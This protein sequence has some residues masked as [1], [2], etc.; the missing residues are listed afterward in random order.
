MDRDFHYYGTVLAAAC[1]GFSPDAARA[2]G[3]SAQFIDDCT[4]ALTHTGGIFSLGSRAR[5]FNVR[6]S[7]G[8]I[9]PFFPL[10]TSVYGVT[11]WA[12]SS[13]YDETRQIWMPFHFLPGNFPGQRSKLVELRPGIDAQGDLTNDSAESIQLLC[14][15][16]SDSA[17]NMINFARTAFARIKGTDAELAQMVV[18]CV[19]HVFADTYAHQDFAGTASYALNGLK[20]GYSKDPGQF[21]LYGEWKGTQWLPKEDT[22]RDIVWPTNVSVDWLNTYPPLAN[23]IA[24]SALGHGQMGHMPDCS[25]LAI[26]YQPAWSNAAIVRNNPQQYMDAFIDMTLALKCILNNWPFDWNNQQMR[27]DH[28]QSLT[29]GQSFTMIKQLFCPDVKSANEIRM[30]DQG[31]CVPSTEWF[32]KSE[33]R[34]GA[35]LAKLLDNVPFNPIPGYNEA[36]YGW[37]KTVEQMGSDPIPLDTF[38]TLQF[39]KWTIAAK[40]LFRANY[41]QLRGMSNGIGRVI[42]SAQFSTAM[43]PRQS[44]IDEFSR[45]W[46]P[47]DATSQTLNDALVTTAS[48][49]EMNSVLLGPYSTTDADKSSTPD[50]F[51]MQREGRCLS[52]S[53]TSRFSSG[54]VRQAFTP[55]VSADATRA[56]PI[57]LVEFNP[58]EGVYLRTFENRVGKQL[59]L[60]YPES[61]VSKILWFNTFDG[62]RNQRWKRNIDP[63]SGLSSFESVRY[64]GW[65][66]GVDGTD[67]KAVNTEVFWQITPYLLNPVVSIPASAPPP[68]KGVSQ[69][70]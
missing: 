33:E 26:R 45:Y 67:V 68:D 35:A 19:M 57:R 56:Q 65:F 60:E 44:V 63:E 70:L 25:C 30:Y 27:D 40:L 3:T 32:Q 14:R 48:S 7:D 55:T 39:F 21:T 36:K 11:T 4:E 24:T 22:F 5:Q 41:G 47:T 58:D 8:T 29:S 64:P 37:P 13:D 54:A 28:I 17:Q 12:P 66:L 23:N 38:K 18:G 9:Y 69:H 49:D 43:D 1:A 46:N 10:I 34:W 53:A 59:F 51:V 31:L 15:P 62:S 42:R 6:M 52:F 16:R 2:I 50:W 20:N 61:I